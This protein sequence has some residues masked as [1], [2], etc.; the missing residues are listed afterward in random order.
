MRAD[1]REA[2]TARAE[3]E[4]RQLACAADKYPAKHP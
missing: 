3:R 4:V 1:R 2:V